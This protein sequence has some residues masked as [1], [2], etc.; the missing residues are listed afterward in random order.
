MVR[1]MGKYVT[2]SAK[3]KTSLWER[4][5]KFNINV[6]EVIRRALEEEVTRMEEKELAKELEEI[7]K[8]LSIHTD[9]EIVELIRSSREER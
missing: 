7:G 8:T 1:D 6:S 4:I 5:K 3:V 2:V 9:K